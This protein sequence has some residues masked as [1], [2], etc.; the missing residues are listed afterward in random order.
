MEKTTSNFIIQ[1]ESGLAYDRQ[2]G[3][4]NLELKRIKII[5]LNYC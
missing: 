2:N 3:K 1:Q 5:L 4:L